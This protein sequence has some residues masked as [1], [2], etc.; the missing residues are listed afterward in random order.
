MKQG[1]VTL[2]SSG[3]H[4]LSVMIFSRCVQSL[5]LFYISQSLAVSYLE[6]KR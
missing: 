6:E 3:K 2:G 5:Y 4:V 1:C